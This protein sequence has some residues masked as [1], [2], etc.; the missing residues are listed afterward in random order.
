MAEARQV[1]SAEGVAWAVDRGGLWLLCE[2]SGASQWLAYPEAAV[3]DLLSR[4]LSFERTVSLLGP[5]ASLGSDEAERL[6]RRCIEA[7]TEAGF[8]A[9]TGDD[10]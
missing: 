10:G 7:W 5:I 1:R 3:W 2:A 6:V 8:L 9:R 4:G